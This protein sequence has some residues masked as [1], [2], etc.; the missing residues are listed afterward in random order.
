MVKEIRIMSIYF[1]NNPRDLIKQNRTRSITIFS[2]KDLRKKIK[3]H[4]FFH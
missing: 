2:P 4:H 3:H 1:G